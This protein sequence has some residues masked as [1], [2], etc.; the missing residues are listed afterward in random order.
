M[1]WRRRKG[2]PDVIDVRGAGKGGGGGGGMRFPGGGGGGGGLPIPG[3]MSGGGGLVGIILIILFIVLKSCGGG[4]G[5]GF[6]LPDV[7][8]PSAAAPGA[9]KPAPIP[10]DEDPQKDLRDFSVYVF[11]DVQG[12]WRQIFKA[13]G[14]PYENAELV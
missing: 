3:G 14:K 2:S 8:G 12:T 7:I 13:D 6:D 11:E 5:G 1:K 10:A 9:D 4:G